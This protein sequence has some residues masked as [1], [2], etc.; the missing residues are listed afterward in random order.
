VT[1]R[2]KYRKILSAMAPAGALGASLLL[3]SVTPGTAKEEAGGS[4]RRAFDAVPVADRLAAI[5]QAA[6][7]LERGDHP[8][9]KAEQR[10][11]WWGNWRN[12]GWWGPGWR[13]GGWWGPGWRNG[14]WWGPGWRNGGWRGP[15]WRN[16]GW[17]NFWRNW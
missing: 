16:G 17:P 1:L 14:G 9:G 8:A 4:Q 15:G 2:Q 12:G 3:G 5:R 7:D 10:L 6:S 13:N 11:A